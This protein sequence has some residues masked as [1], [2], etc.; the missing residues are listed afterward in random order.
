MIFTAQILVSKKWTPGFADFTQAFH[1]GDAINR[2]LYALQPREGI[3]GASAKQLIK[4]KK[5][6]YGLT[7]GPSAWYAHIVKYLTKT[8]GYRQ[9]IID[10]CLFSLDSDDQRDDIEGI[11][12]LATDDLL[13]G[14]T[15]KASI[16]DGGAETEIYPEKV[17][18]DYWEIRGKEL[19]STGGRFT[20]D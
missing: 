14:G 10:P 13:H 5:T 7:D 12:A 16:Q 6:C 17:Y 18:L 8:L 4:L 9:S 3:P 2:E 1:S 15:D 11:I 19:H 20:S